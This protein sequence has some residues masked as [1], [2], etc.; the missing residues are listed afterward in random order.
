MSLVVGYVH[1]RSRC[2]A[3]GDTLN[4]TEVKMLYD[5]TILDIKTS[6]HRL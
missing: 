1:L 5:S 2:A 3:M 6:G 4:I